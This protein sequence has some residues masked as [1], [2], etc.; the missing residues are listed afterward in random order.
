MM[1][2]TISGIVHSLDPILS[3]KGYARA[4]FNTPD[5]VSVEVEGKKLYFT[6]YDKINVS[7][8]DRVIDITAGILRGDDRNVTWNI[9]FI[10]K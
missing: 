10:T 9:E 3:P 2:A 8:T 4:V 5:R 7:P 1:K 6:C